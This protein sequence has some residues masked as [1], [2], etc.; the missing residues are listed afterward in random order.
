MS[1][2]RR[3]WPVRDADMSATLPNPRTRST[4]R[5]RTAAQTVTCARKFAKFHPIRSF[6]HS[7][8]N[9]F[10]IATVVT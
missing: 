5:K 3:A 6:A 1:P 4:A 7:A 8:F 2:E 9:T 10:R